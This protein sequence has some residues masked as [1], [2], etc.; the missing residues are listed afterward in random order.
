MADIIMPLRFVYRKKCIYGEKYDGGAREYGWIIMGCVHPKVSHL[1]R[2]RS[3]LIYIYD[4]V[5][6]SVLFVYI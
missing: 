4:Y 5:Y 6:A 1:Y 3:L 2:L